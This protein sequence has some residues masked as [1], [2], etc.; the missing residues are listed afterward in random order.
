MGQEVGA[1]RGTGVLVT[2]PQTP[3]WPDLWVLPHGSP[4]VEEGCRHRTS[5]LKDRVVARGEKENAND[6]AMPS[7]LSASLSTDSE[8]RNVTFLLL[9]EANRPLSC[10][11][12]YF[13]DNS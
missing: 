13:H 5:L 7:L 1:E 6:R 11:H 9:G 3:G 10:L 8:E 4:R 12:N 2:G